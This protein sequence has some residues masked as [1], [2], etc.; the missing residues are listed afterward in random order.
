MCLFF[1]KTQNLVF[2]TPSPHKDEAFFLLQQKGVADIHKN[3]FH[4][5]V[6]STCLIGKNFFFPFRYASALHADVKKNLIRTVINSGINKQILG[7]QGTYNDRS[8]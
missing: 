5:P 3:C 7:L 2:R 1:K 8:C 4:S 6:K